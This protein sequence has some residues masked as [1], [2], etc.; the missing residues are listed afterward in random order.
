[1][2]QPY[3]V[4]LEAFEGP[5]DLLLHLV[6]K[7]EIDIYDIPVAQITEQY[8]NYIHQM[9]YL[10]LN[11]ASEYLVM[12][13]TL[14]ALKSRMLLPRQELDQ[15]D[16]AMDED[17]REELVEKLIEY[18]KFK[19]AALLLRE[20]EDLPVFTRDPVYDPQTQK[21][22]AQKSA[23][24]ESSIYDLLGALDRM[25]ERKKWNKPLR[26]TIQ[27]SEIPIKQRMEQ[28][29]E[30]LGAAPAGVLF[31]QLF[32]YPSKSHIVV[33]FLA[34]LELIKENLVI[35]Q[36]MKQFEDIHIY[37]TSREINSP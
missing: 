20:K 7:Y 37:P 5:L 2:N 13:A 33:T 23:P 17:P 24:V 25:F 28:I 3:E 1:M 26:T 15:E 34:L 31:D 29:M 14:L 18:Q 35:C 10:E 22:S 32:E 4:K 12:A 19:A 16:E 36:Q 11:V 30:Q 6:H 27:R 9:Q 8:M 21:E